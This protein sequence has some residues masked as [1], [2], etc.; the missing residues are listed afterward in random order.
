[1]TL[2]NYWVFAKI[3]RYVPQMKGYEYPNKLPN[4]M[5]SWYLRIKEITHLGIIL[6][7]VSETQVYNITITGSS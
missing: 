2:G 4:N 3:K 5:I 7:S 6:Y 1:V